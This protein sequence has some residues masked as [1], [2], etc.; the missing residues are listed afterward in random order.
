M[1]QKVLRKIEICLQA[2]LHHQEHHKCIP[3]R[4]NI[5]Q[6]IIND[7]TIAQEVQ[8]PMLQNHNSTVNHSLQQNVQVLYKNKTVLP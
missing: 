3:F 7:Q 6:H 4:L 8:T 5:M 2:G 1:W